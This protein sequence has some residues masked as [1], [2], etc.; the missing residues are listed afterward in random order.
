MGF[1]QSTHPTDKRPR[2]ARHF[3]VRDEHT[4]PGHGRDGIEALRLPVAHVTNRI[5]RARHLIIEP[6]RRAVKDALGGVRPSIDQG[7]RRL[8]RADCRSVRGLDAQRHS[9]AVQQG[10]AAGATGLLAAA[11]EAQPQLEQRR[12]QR[13]AERGARAKASAQRQ[14]R[15]AYADAQARVGVGGRIGHAHHRGFEELG[16]QSTAQEEQRHEGSTVG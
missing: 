9:R 16:Q 10:G 8:A 13:H 5:A 3:C 15:A 11:K 7:L 12:R 6:T 2:R 14:S 1:V 4:Q